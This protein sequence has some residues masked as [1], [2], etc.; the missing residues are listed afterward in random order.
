MES[1]STL[2]KSSNQPKW[3]STLPHILQSRHLHCIKQTPQSAK[4]LHDKFGFFANGP[5]LSHEV[6]HHLFEAFCEDD[7]DGLLHL[8][9]IHEIDPNCIV[10]EELMMGRQDSIQGLG[11]P[12][13]IVFWREVPSNEMG[14]WLDIKYVTKQLLDNDDRIPSQ[15]LGKFDNGLKQEGKVGR[16]LK[17]VRQSSIH[18]IKSMS[19]IGDDEN[20]IH[21]T[22]ESDQIKSFCDEIKHKWIK[23]ELLA[24]RKEYFGQK[25]GSL[26]LACA[27]YQAYL[28][29][30]SRAVL[31]VAGGD[32]NIPAVRLYRHFGFLPVSQGGMFQKPDRDLYILGDIGRSLEDLAWRETLD[33][34]KKPT[35]SLR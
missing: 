31:H 32:D 33:V 27:L 19:V 17:L 2:R 24:V 30:K 8:T 18:S 5:E 34:D 6:E 26:L 13:G 16:S 7:Y 22:N 21:R 25:I 15:Q 14:E 1:Q 28:R 4:E 9:T 12:V 11:K 23:I 20:A 10:D 3:T 35:N 29:T